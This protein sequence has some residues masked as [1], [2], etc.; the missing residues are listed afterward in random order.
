MQLSVQLAKTVCEPGSPAPGPGITWEA[1]ARGT[2]PHEGSNVKSTDSRR[3]RTGF[4][5]E[6]WLAEKFKCVRQE[7]DHC[8]K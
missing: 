3:P 5:T 8:Q 2:C 6:Q 4:G 1:S 7:A